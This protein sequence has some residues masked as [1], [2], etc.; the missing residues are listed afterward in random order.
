MLGGA[1]MPGRASRGRGFMGGNVREGRP[2]P[3]ETLPA[4]AAVRFSIGLASFD[5]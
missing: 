1:K 4:P 2:Q 5:L 3:L